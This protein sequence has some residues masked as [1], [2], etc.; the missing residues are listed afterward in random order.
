M[1]TVAALQEIFDVALPSVW[2]ARR[3][4]IFVEK[5]SEGIVVCLLT[6]FKVII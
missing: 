2:I 3:S 4:E 6:I 1:N 5:F